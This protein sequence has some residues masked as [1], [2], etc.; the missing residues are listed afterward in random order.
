MTEVASS[1]DGA[2]LSL[3]GKKKKVNQRHKDRPP[4]GCH[5]N[6]ASASLLTRDNLLDCEV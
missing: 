5:G 1:L 6:I 3:K 2:T 4:S